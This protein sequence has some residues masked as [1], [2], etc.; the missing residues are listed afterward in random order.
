MTT[1]EARLL[2]DGVESLRGAV[3]LAEAKRAAVEDIL[4]ALAYEA[5]EDPHLLAAVAYRIHT[6]LPVAQ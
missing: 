3:S 1:S 6:I 4:R 2:L 5:P